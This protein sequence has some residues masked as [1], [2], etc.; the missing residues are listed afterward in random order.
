M[1]RRLLGATGLVAVFVTMVSFEAKAQNPKNVKKLDTVIDS[2]KLAEGDYTGVLVATPGTDRTYMLTITK[3]TLVPVPRTGKGVNPPRQP[4][5]GANMAG[6]TNALNKVVNLNNQVIAAQNKVNSA[7]NVKARNAAL[8]KYNQLAGQLQ[9][10]ILTFQTQATQA[11]LT[12]AMA[13]LRAAQQGS[14][15]SYR[16]NTT[17]QDYEF[18]NI[19]EVVVRTQ[20]LPDQFDEKGNPKKYTKEELDELKGKD[21][22]APGYES[23]LDKLEAGQTLKVTLVTVK[24]KVDKE[25][26]KDA[27]KEKD[28]EKKMQVKMIIIT[29]E[30]NTNTKGK[31][32]NKDNN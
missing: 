1:L 28:T 15:T 9:G 8:Q 5:I 31:N 20:V 24:K 2:E 25:K 29:K 18:Q 19:E 11:G 16:V 4:N 12:N 21:K 22:K 30:A 3:Q 10:A 27:D 14:N 23:S 32:K 6:V 26:D 17:R 7:T 13:L